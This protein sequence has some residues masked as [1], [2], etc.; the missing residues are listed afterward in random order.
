MDLKQFKNTGADFKIKKAATSF[1]TGMD[2]QEIKDELAATMDKIKQEQRKLFAD[3]RYGIIVV[4]QAMDAAGKDSLISHVFSQVNPGGLRVANFN[5]PSSTELS[6]DFLWR[7]TNQLP[8]RGEIG[9]LN[10]SHYED[11]LVSKVHPQLIV[12]ANLPG[13]YTLDDVTPEFF[14]QRYQDI[15]NYESYLTHSGF[16]ILKF[17]LHV[18]KEEQ[19]QRF[20]ARIERPEKNW[21]FEKADI[22]ERRY[23][24]DYQ[25]AYQ[26][27][28]RATSSKEN[29][30]YIIPADDK[31][32]SRLIVAKIMVK[33][34]K[35]LNLQFP[36]T[37]ADQKQLMADAL[38]ILAEE[39]WMAS[40]RIIR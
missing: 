23:W 16:V 20:L 9:I 8:E 26:D 3:R 28:I 37:E 5:R 25:K 34:I 19:K 33:R 27:A 12:N 40:P 17:F 6:H 2:R 36:I 15:N 21:K 31:W 24:D 30:W 4:L 38:K 11:V 14:K 32:T 13:I 18:S 39:K 1:D 35:Q 7:I 29:P 10:R 22:A